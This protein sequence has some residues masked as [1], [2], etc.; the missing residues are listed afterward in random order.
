MADPAKQALSSVGYIKE[1]LKMNSLKNNAAR[2]AALGMAVVAAVT[3]MAA[4]ADD[5]SSSTVNTLFPTFV[6][7]IGSIL[8]ANLPLV[9]VVLAGLIGLGIMVY[10]VRRWIGH[11]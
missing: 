8:T 6:Q 9:L 10:Y 2:Y 1:N 4:R 11:K 5:F 7:D 3:G